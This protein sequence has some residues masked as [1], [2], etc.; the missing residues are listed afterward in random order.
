MNVLLICG[1]DV[2]KSLQDVCSKAKNKNVLDTV[3]QIG[4]DIVEIINKS[5]KPH[6]IVWG[7]G[8]EIKSD[9]SETDLLLE[10]HQAFPFIRI[11]VNHG[12]TDE[13]TDTLI[14]NNIYDIIARVV[15]EN[16]FISVLN[17]PIT[18]LEEYQSFNA[19]KYHKTTPKQSD[20][21]KIVINKSSI[22]L[23]CIILLL[24]IGIAVLKVNGKPSENTVTTEPTTETVTEK[25]TQL[26]TQKPT[27]VVT[28]KPTVIPVEVATQINTQIAT[29]QT[30]TSSSTAKSD[31]TQTATEKA[32]KKTEKSNQQSTPQSPSP[33]SNTQTPVQKDNN[34]QTPIQQPVQQ[35]EQ[36]QIV[37]P[38]VQPTQPPATQPVQS[39]PQPVPTDDGKIYFDQTT[40]S[41]TTGT[42]FEVFVNGLSAENGCEWEIGNSSIVEFVSSQ[43]TGVLL[44]AKER[45]T[46]MITSTAIK[47]GATCQAIITVR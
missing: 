32:T 42:T 30:A 13:F 9:K 10:I 33:N 21:K 44:R 34:N 3:S 40:Y 23:L 5:Y 46:T 35:Q 28:E 43:S 45:G 20:R 26:P 12:K 36:P 38:T 6:M 24:G 25:V 39:N 37:Q 16:E 18:S 22:I 27:L 4:D 2:Q 8:I 14:K 31:T 41:V 15:T 47:N 29:Q 19:P 11:I 17:N 7:Q 1:K